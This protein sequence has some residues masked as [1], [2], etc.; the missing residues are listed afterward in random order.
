MKPCI[1][2]FQT[3][4]LIDCSCHSIN[5]AELGP[6]SESSCSLRDADDGYMYACVFVCVTKCVYME[7]PNECYRN[8]WPHL[9][10]FLWARLWWQKD[11]KIQFLSLLQW[12]I[13]KVAF[14]CSRVQEREPLEVR[15]HRGARVL[16]SPRG[17]VVRNSPANAGDAGL[18]PES[19]RSPGG[20][21]GSPLQYSYLGNPMETRALW[22]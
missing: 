3:W 7:N 14:K 6:R 21:N 1:S 19:G 22:L 5:P 12:E 13:I 4:F 10:Q 8:S 2:K 11:G 9:G 16:G 18:I 20:G 17:S 15:L